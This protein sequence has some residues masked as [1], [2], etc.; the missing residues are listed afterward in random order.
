TLNDQGSTNQAYSFVDN[1]IS[2]ALQ[3]LTYSGVQRLTLNGGSG[4][5]FFRVQSTAAGTAI[6][7]NGGNGS[8]TLIGPGSGFPATWAITGRNA[9][10]LSAPNILSPVSFTAIRN[11]R[12]SGGASPNTLRFSDGASISGMIEGLGINDTLDL[13]AYTTA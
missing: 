7:L 3:P 8:N 2:G 11:L 4:Q 6:T 13:S 9:G 5:D 1:Q 10:T 12:T